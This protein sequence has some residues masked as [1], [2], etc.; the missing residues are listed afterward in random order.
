MHGGCKGCYV[1]KKEFLVGM[2][3]IMWVVGFFAL[4]NIF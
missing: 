4:K 1:L 3:I 2:E